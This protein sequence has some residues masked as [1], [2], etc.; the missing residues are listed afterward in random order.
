MKKVSK[1]II[2]EAISDILDVPSN[3]AAGVKN[4]AASGYGAYNSGK[5]SNQLKRTAEKIGKEWKST[6]NAIKKPVVKMHASGNPE[7]KQKAIA[8]NNQ[9]QSIDKDVATI[10]KKMASV[11]SSLGGG[12][13]QSAGRG[14]PLLNPFDDP[15]DFED[16]ETTTA[17]GNKQI[18]TPIQRWVKQMGMGADTKK[19]GVHEWAKINKAWLEMRTAGINPFDMTPM[20]S[21][22]FLYYERLRN[23]AIEG[24][25]GDPYAGWNDHWDYIFGKNKANQMRQRLA[26]H[27]GIQVSELKDFFGVPN[28]NPNPPTD[29]TSSAPSTTTGTAQEQRKAFKAEVASFADIPE[30]IERAILKL[31]REKGIEKAREAFERYKAMHA[32]VQARAQQAQSQSPPEAQQA[33]PA[34]ST[35]VP[36]PQ[37]QSNVSSPTAAPQ[38]PQKSMSPQIEPSI[39]HSEK[40]PEILPA[41]PNKFRKDNPQLALPKPAMPEMPISHSEKKVSSKGLA[42]PAVQAN[43]TKQV[44]DDPRLR[45]VRIDQPKPIGD[46]P[47]PQS[48]PPVKQEPVS[49]YAPKLTDF[50]SDSL[51]VPEEPKKPPMIDKGNEIQVGDTANPGFGPPAE[52]KKKAPSKKRPTSRPKKKTTKKQDS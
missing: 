15:A 2:Q 39:S 38:A 36:A 45:S 13:G 42:T 6:S 24:G 21:E 31:M 41:P 5:V 40:Q 20:E 16:R 14:G 19:I 8:I 27:Y 33:S 7:V 23:K 51:P 12:S 26:S 17:Y 11:D 34:S 37:T 3:I 4:V 30:T 48:L 1:Q 49:A 10:M 35:P 32:G 44:K 50:F 22:K 52:G 46:V 29:Q 43:Q 28:S 47:Q 18:E 9:F 25:Q